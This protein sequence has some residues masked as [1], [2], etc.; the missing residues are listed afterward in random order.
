MRSIQKAEPAELDFHDFDSLLAA[1]ESGEAGSFENALVPIDEYEAQGAYR[2]R[3]YV[4]PPASEADCPHCGL[5]GNF[6]DSAGFFT[7]ERCDYYNWEATPD[8][9]CIGQIEFRESED[10][11]DMDDDSPSVGAT[12]DRRALDVDSY[13][14][15]VDL[16]DGFSTGT[17]DELHADELN[18]A[19]AA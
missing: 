11:D 15:A 19:E 3:E 14:D 8:T 9:D 17:L 2:V 7:C 4:G 5:G 1:V 12:V 13:F 16:R 10:G 6:V 18:L